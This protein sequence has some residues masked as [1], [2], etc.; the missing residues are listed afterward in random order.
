[1]IVK[2]FNNHRLYKLR[3]LYLQSMTRNTNTKKISFLSSLCRFLSVIV[4]VFLLSFLTVGNVFIYDKG[5]GK[6]S[7][8]LNQEASDEDLGCNKRPLSPEEEKSSSISNSL[9]E[10]YLHNSDPFMHFYTLITS[11]RHEYIHPHGYGDDHSSLDCPP[12]DQLLS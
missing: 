1:M 3:S 2:I 6:Q 5:A 10:E 9:T 4:M 11:S 8:V 12:P 7:M